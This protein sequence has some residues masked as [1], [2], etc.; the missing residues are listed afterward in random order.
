VAENVTISYRGA[1]YEIG[2]GQGFYGIWAAGMPREQPLE[3]WPETP[4]GWYAAWARFSGIEA[5]GTIAA[6]GPT[7]A[8]AITQPGYAAAGQPGDQGATQPGAQLAARPPVGGVRAIVAVVLLGVGVA[9]GIAGLFPDYFT[10]ASLAHDAGDLVPHAIYLAAWAASAVLILLGGGRLRLGALLG[11]GVSIVTFGMFF[12]DAGTVMA[13]GSHLLGAGLVLSLV[14]WIACAAGSLVAFEGW[15]AGVPGGARG[16]RPGLVVAS[17]ITA[18]GAAIAFA[19]SWDSYTLRTS[20][21]LDQ[22]V[23][24]GNAFSNP[25][26]V[27]AGDVVVMVALVVVAILA[28]RWRPIRLGAA[29]LAGAIIPLVAQAI[30]AIIE[31]SEPAS[32]LQFGIPAAQ[33]RQAGLSISSG[34]TP[35]FWVYCV[36][37]VGLAVTC[38]VMF[39]APR[40]AAVGLTATAS[41][42][43]GPPATAGHI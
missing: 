32:S 24:A 4:E 9:C 30:S 35:V 21:G 15:P 10:G 5:P 12:A 11:L 7:A 42:P 33:A 25:A 41:P 37:V 28:A 38:A 43:T 3:W 18:I 6:V 27:I 23:T 2:R 8:Q 39:R 13:G 31:I 1:R 36:F 19:P 29:L 17:G 16:F 26:P 20:A 40:Q 22:T 34:L 14:G